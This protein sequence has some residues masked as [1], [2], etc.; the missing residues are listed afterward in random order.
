M[1]DHGS[2][3]EKILG[4]LPRYFGY[5]DKIVKAAV[6]NMYQPLFYARP[7]AEELSRKAAHG[8]RGE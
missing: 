8:G 3:F 7:R 6:F 2:V 4:N 5:R 1:I